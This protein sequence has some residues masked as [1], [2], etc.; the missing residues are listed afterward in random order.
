MAQFSNHRSPNKRSRS[1]G[2][3]WVGIAVSSVVLMSLLFLPGTAAAA[4]CDQG[5]VDRTWDGEGPLDNW[6]NPVNWSG[7][8]LPQATEDVCIP[9]QPG[10]PTIVISNSQGANINSFESR[11]ALTILGSQLTLAAASEI[12]A[13]YLFNLAGGSVG[14]AG[15]LTVSGP[16][17]WTEGGMNGS[18]T[19]V[20][21]G[22]TTISGGGEKDLSSRT[23]TN[24]GTINWASGDLRVYSGTIIN[25]SVTGV[26]DIQSDADIVHVGGGVLGDLNNVGLLKKSGG[27]E[28]NATNI[29][30][31][32]DNTGIDPNG[33]EVLSGRLSLA[34]GGLS[35]GHFETQG[36]GE[37]LEFSGGTHVLTKS[38]P[39]DGLG[40]IRFSGGN[41][42]VTDPG[43]DLAGLTRVTGGTVNFNAP[44][45]TDS[46][47]FTGGTIGGSD[48]KQPPQQSTLTVTTGPTLWTGGAFV[49]DGETILNGITT[50]SGVV[51]SRNIHSR[52][53]T[54]NGTVNLLEDLRVGSGGT[55]HNSTTGIFDIQADA[56]ILYCCAG[57]KGTFDNLGLLRQTANPPG[58]TTI[59]MFLN[60]TGTI[61]LR[62]LDKLMVGGATTLGGT[63]FIDDVG[64]PAAGGQQFELMTYP[65]GTGCFTSLQD[66]GGSPDAIYDFSC[67]PTNVLVTTTA[68]EDTEISLKS[69]AQVAYGKQFALSG[70]VTSGNSVC[71]A[72][73]N[74]DLLQR[75]G[76]TSNFVPLSTVSTN[77]AGNFTKSLTADK[78][79]T[80][81]ARLVKDAPCAGDE[82]PARSTSVNMKVKLV[83]SADKV[84][85]GDK[86]TMTATVTPCGDHAGFVA[87]L[88]KRIDRTSQRGFLLDKKD[89]NG[90]C[91]VTFERKINK[92]T[93]F[94]VEVI[95]AQGHVDHA[96]GVSAWLP[97]GIK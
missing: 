5:V 76:G 1:P 86:V 65:S 94:K 23:L 50:L 57:A 45:S 91:K 54:N 61:R 89:L 39:L 3:R 29:N 18:G 70:A 74:V 37:V 2:Y 83:S 80:Y 8:I 48:T 38:A 34:G 58:P 44:A 69:P 93:Q 53:L 62:P 88:F 64:N 28:P 10:T 43:Y 56:D 60:S 31:N 73:V 17:S 12:D 36:P 25:N 15:M 79:A 68:L 46:L 72:S 40:E 59:D 33:I 41:A 6:D 96:K 87:K 95:P 30:M 24:N 75:I 77:T 97:I 66:N 4:A 71:K 52:T 14:G 42:T 32:V 82:S 9:D 78:S 7:D 84:E 49:G 51:E 81:K 11:E 16:M 19:S 90:Q 27:S 67:S 47:T 92:A 35:W 13:P 21:N 26:I 63:L 20:L 55:I 85:E 22:I